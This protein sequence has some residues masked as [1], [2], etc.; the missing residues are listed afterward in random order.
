MVCH[1]IAWLDGGRVHS[2]AFSGGSRDSIRFHDDLEYFRQITGASSVM[3]ARA[4]MWNP[5][6]FSPGELKESVQ[7]VTEY[8]KLV[9]HLF[10]TL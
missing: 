5:S 9:R 6:I 10:F 4:A 8:L 1:L 3:V 7:L 2:L